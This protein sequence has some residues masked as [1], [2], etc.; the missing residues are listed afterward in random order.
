MN[1]ERSFGH[2]RLI[3]LSYKITFIYFKSRLHKISLECKIEIDSKTLKMYKQDLLN[4]R[5]IISR[6]WFFFTFLYI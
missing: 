4:D 6:L 1:C 2:F 5:M 3:Y